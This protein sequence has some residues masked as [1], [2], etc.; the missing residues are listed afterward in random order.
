MHADDGELDRAGR[1][2]AQLHLQ[3]VA[4]SPVAAEDIIF[5]LR[6]FAECSRDAVHPDGAQVRFGLGAEAHGLGA[7]A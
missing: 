6:A 3:P 1:S 5:V 4:A 7:S 2:D